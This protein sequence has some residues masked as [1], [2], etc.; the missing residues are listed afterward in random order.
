MFSLLGTASQY[1]DGPEPH[2]SDPCGPAT[3]AALLATHGGHAV[4][5]GALQ[6]E[7]LIM[8]NPQAQSYSP[9]KGTM[10]RI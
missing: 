7:H 9:T 2:I 10:P 3:T 5:A 6:T 8:W 1:A 4:C